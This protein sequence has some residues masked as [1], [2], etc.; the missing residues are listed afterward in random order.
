MSE[1]ITNS[2]AGAAARR[3]EPGLTSIVVPLYNEQENVAQ[4]AEA[5]RS[6]MNGGGYELILV[7]DGSED[8]TAETITALADDDG[9]ICGLSLS[10]NFGHQYALAAGLEYAAGDVVITMDGDMQHPPELLPKLIEQWR[11]GYNIVQAKRTG[12]EG[13]GALKRWSSRLYYRCFRF[14]CGIR[15]ED[16]MT[17]FRLLDRTVVDEI[18]KVREGQLFLRGL[19]AW[20]GYRRGVVEFTA[21]RR[22]AGR[23]KYGLRRLLKLARSGLLSFSPAPM[24]VGIVIGLVMSV[25]SFLELGYVLIVTGLGRTVPGW[26]SIVGLL[27]LLFGVMFLLIGLQGEYL[28]RIYERV[29]HRPGFLV[30]RTIGK[31][32]IPSPRKE[33]SA[34]TASREDDDKPMLKIRT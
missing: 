9:R 6:V 20:M 17:D 11:D 31:L 33:E 2:S 26:A 8:A 1:E 14:L 32:R 18:N 25:L 10:R 13:V 3:A 23:S 16:G 34:T 24:R 4:L 27:S 19:I 15:L 21:P 12:T 30:E 28:I 7:D 5:I 22:S 29:Q